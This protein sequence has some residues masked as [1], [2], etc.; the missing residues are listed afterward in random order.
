METNFKKIIEEIK[1]ETVD[2]KDTKK[3][4]LA[5]RSVLQRVYDNCKGEFSEE[6]IL[7]DF[8]E[9]YEKD[10]DFRG[11][12]TSIF[13]GMAKFEA[14]TG[15]LKEF[16]GNK[17]NFNSIVREAKKI[18]T[19]EQGKL[20]QNL[21]TDYRNA[22]VSAVR[23]VMRARRISSTSDIIA[24]IEEEKEKLEAD[25]RKKLTN[26]IHSSVSML[27]EYGFLDE[28]IESSNKELEQIGLSEIQFQ[29]RNPIPDEQYD[30]EG[31]LVQDVEDIGVIDALTEEELEK[32]PLGELQGMAAFYESK[33]FQ[34]R[35][36]VSKAMSVIKTL[37]M[38]DVLL[39]GSE[40]DIEAIDDTKID[41]ALRKDLA[42]SYLSKDVLNITNKMRKQYR[43]FLKQYGMYEKKT[44]EEEAN[45][46]AP[47]MSNLQG[48][49]TDIAIL[50]GLVMEQ[51]KTGSMKVKKW[52]ILEVDEDEV[53]VAIESKNF[54]GPLVMGVSKPLIARFCRTSESQL[55]KYDKE[56]DAT[57]SS[58]MSKIYIPAN[59]FYR[60]AVAK[61]H[62]ENPDSKVIADLAER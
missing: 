10:L 40:A 5:I 2:P 28:Y 19:T 32:I 34:E 39:H 44:I 54:R 6:E 58:I 36:G 12:A 45:E 30:S 41:G 26:I 23:Y 60:K 61:A 38:W 47:E 46:V 1:E 17:S 43:K 31:N 16:K 25:L 52:G 42:I 18:E 13:Y 20:I 62:A 24:A 11:D 55:P 57:Y 29:K 35:L 9:E 21:Q 15:V 48:A 3:Y 27:D 4:I 53:A 33:Y 14:Y 51:L 37:E 7:S 50:E 49:V 59:N 56:V 8:L 22:M